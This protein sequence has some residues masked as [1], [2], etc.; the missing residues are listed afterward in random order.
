MLVVGYVLP[1]DLVGKVA[2]AMC[3]S[4]NDVVVV[5]P[6]NVP[7]DLIESKRNILMHF[8]ITNPYSEL[9][10]LLTGDRRGKPKPRCRNKYAN[11]NE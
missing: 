6:A 8:E 7:K 11:F 3:G 1:H 9:P 4:K 2:Q 10:K 5:G